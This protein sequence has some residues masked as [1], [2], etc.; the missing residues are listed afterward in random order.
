MKNNYIDSSGMILHLTTNKR[1]HNAGVLMVGQDYL[2]LPPGE[3][4]VTVDGTCTSDM[5][6][7]RM[8]GPVKFTRGLNHMHYLGMCTEILILLH[9]DIICR[10]ITLFMPTINSW[11]TQMDMSKYGSTYGII[12]ISVRTVT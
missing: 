2:E 10:K 12:D 7:L 5:S 3:E 9:D 1:T 4:R 11:S 8:T 6:T